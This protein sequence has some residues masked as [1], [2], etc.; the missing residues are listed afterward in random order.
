[1]YFET[2][3]KLSKEL[4]LTFGQKLRT[5]FYENL[6]GFE[7]AIKNCRGPRA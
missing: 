2:D 4:I 3:L 5:S 1:M 6:S 7:E